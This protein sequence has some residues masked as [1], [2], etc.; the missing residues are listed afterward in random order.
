MAR[1][2]AALLGMLPL[3][4]R[5]VSAQTVLAHFMAQESYSYSQDDWAKDISSAQSIGIDGFVLNVALSDYEVDRIVDA[6]AAAEAAGFKLVYSFDFAGGH[7][8]QDEVVSLI[9]AHKDSDANYKWQDK[10]LVSTYSGSEQGN[11]F[12]QGVKDSLSGQGVEVT[13]AP[14]F[15]DYRETG[16]AQEVFSTFPAIDGFVNWWSWPADVN[17]ELTTE[18][19]LA[20]QSAVKDAG[21]GGPFIMSVSPWQF[22]SLGGD[23]W[24]EQSDTLWNY[25]WKQAV[26]EVHPDIVEIV[27]WNDYGEAHYISDINY[28]V[29]MGDA[30]NYV[31]GIEHGAWRTVAQYYI[32]WYKSGSAPAIEEDT[33]V[34]WYRV[35][36]KGVKCDAGT[37]P[38]MADFP[39]DAVFALAMLADSTGEATIS[40]DVG[41]SH[42]EFTANGGNLTIGKVPFPTEDGQTPYFTILKDGQKSKEGS[43]NHNITTACPYYNYNPTVGQL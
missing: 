4:A 15:V 34:Y 32:S 6:F 36:P 33:L 22:K 24:V 5:T 43:G 1:S 21:R 39:E 11:D 16:K 30:L 40:L 23:G 13:W 2:I 9:A 7:W 18:T 8:S 29:D 41:S 12:Y 17:E 37:E 26:D 10:I 3:F 25:R 14:A 38:R 19:D 31:N 35:H 27:T 28:N 20:Y 42:S